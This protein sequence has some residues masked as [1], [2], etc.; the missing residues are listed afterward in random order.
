MTPIALALAAMLSLGATGSDQPARHTELQAAYPAADTVHT[1][2]VRE[3]RLR[4]ST[5]VQ[6]ALSTVTVVGPEGVLR[7]ADS[8]RYVDGAEETE[9]QL[10]LAS[11]LTTGEYTVEWRTAG[12]DGHAIRGDYAFRVEW[13]APVDTAAQVRPADADSADLV[14]VTD[15]MGGDAEASG[16]SQGIARWL[17]YLAVAAAFGGSVFSILV[18][19]PIGRGEGMEE[20]AAGAQARIGTLTW[21]GVAAALVALPV[22]L[23][24]ASVSFFGGSPWNAANIARTLGSQWGASWWIE[25]TGLAAVVLGLLLRG[26][27]RLPL[28]RSVITVGAVA[29]MFGGVSAGHAVSEG[30]L[31]VVVQTVHGLAAATW[32]GGLACLVLAAIPATRKTPAALPAV[33]AKFSP[34]ALA[35]VAVI[36]GT[37]VANSWGRVGPANLLTSG[38]GLTLLLKLGIFAGV[39]ALGFHNWRT[40]RPTLEVDPRPALLRVPATLELAL[41]AAVLLVTAFLVVTPLP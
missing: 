5:A 21:M 39:A 37:G 8:L 41:G 33:V 7:T 35:S 36:V 12:P 1:E 40:V 38:Y 23:G 25:L 19:G 31:S 18:V 22:S 3:I 17:L 34:V 2:A 27:D 29:L 24:L 28:G 13:E 16:R 10:L 26:Q 20:V 14:E 6:L 30:T 15:E 4:Y 32:L 9:L 11:P